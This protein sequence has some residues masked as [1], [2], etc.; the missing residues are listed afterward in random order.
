MLVPTS[1][2]YTKKVYEIMLCFRGGGS[3]KTSR[4]GDEQI[5]VI[6]NYYIYTK[7]N[8]HPVCFL[9]IQVK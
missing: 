1:F 6:T 9:L 8:T 5:C 2:K 4:E 7:H 3:W